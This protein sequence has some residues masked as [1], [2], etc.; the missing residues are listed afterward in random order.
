MSDH[1]ETLLR[2]AVQTLQMTAP[3][4]DEISASA[5]R[6]AGHLGIVE[7]GLQGSPMKETIESCEDVQR[8]LGSY[9]AGKLSG[10]RA[11]LL[12]AHL[13]DCGACL[14]RFRSG[15]GTEAVDWSTPKVRRTIACSS[16]LRALC[17]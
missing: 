9:R 14:S 7:N 2:K 11:L 16:S 15:S 6:V 3:D 13:R 1:E 8:L 5:R 12:E 17:L 10:P 4:A